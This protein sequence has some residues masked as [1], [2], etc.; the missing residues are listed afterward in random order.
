MRV[1][2]RREF[3]PG[4]GAELQ[5]QVVMSTADNDGR[6]TGHETR[7]SQKHEDSKF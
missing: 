7:P 4:F 5:T 2:G 3:Q 1:S 6:E